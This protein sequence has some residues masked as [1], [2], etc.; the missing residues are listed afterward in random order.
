MVEIYLADQA[1]ENAWA[2]VEGFEVS[3]RLSLQL[4]RE[5]AKASLNRDWS[6]VFSVF[7]EQAEHFIGL[8]NNDAYQEAISLLLELGS[9]A[10]ESHHQ[11]EA[12]KGIAMLKEKYKRKRNFIRFLGERQRVLAEEL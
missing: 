8:G 10:K 12:E 6:R 11:S 5:S 2:V 9:F 3:E 7:M 4:A 1:L